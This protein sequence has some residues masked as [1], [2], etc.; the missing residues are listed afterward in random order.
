MP[1]KQNTKHNKEDNESG[2]QRAK[3][4]LESEPEWAFI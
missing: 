2:M 1:K 3:E 4:A